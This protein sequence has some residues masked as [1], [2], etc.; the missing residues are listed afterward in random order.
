M[1]RLLTAKCFFE[2]PQ[3]CGFIV[4]ASQLYPPIEYDYVT[5]TAPIDSLSAFAKE[6]G[7]SYFD[8][9]QANLWLRSRA[10][11]VKSN[12]KYL[13]AI[14][15]KKSQYYKPEKVKAHNAKWVVE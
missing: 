5:V 13:I 2:N 10:L 12:Q 14:P 1:F 6:Q 8:I 15:T 4:K 11:P 3:Q 9:K 7:V